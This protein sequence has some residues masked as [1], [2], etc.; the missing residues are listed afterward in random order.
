VLTRS[1]DGSRSIALQTRKGSDIENRQELDYT[2]HQRQMAE[3]QLKE[4]HPLVVARSTQRRKATNTYNCHGL[5]FASRRTCIH[6]ERIVNLILSDDGYHPIN[7][8]DVL[9]G[10][11][12]LYY[13]R[14]KQEL[15]HSGV[16]VGVDSLGRTPVI[17]I[18]SK[19]GR[20]GEYLHELRTHPYL[21]ATKHRFMRPSHHDL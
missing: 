10:D 21:S 3:G 19:W 13:E 11:I 6:E 1:L 9:P 14:D 5:T 4:A 7:A 8:Q 17:T 2:P 12:V 20:Y 15:A 16:V 18:L